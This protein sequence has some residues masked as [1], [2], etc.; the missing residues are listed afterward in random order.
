MERIVPVDETPASGARW[1]Y[2]RP[3]IEGVV[4]LG[5]VHGRNVGLPRHFHDEHQVTFVVSGRR[6]FFV[7]GEVTVLT[8]GEGTLIPAGVPHYSL[9]EPAGVVCL[10]AYIPAGEYAVS[11]MIEA[12]GLQWRKAG[13]VRWIELAAVIRQHWLGPARGAPSTGNVSNTSRS[14]S[15]AAIQAGMSREGY[16]RMFARHSGMPPHAHGVMHRLNQARRLLRVG[17]GIA[18]VAAETGFADQSHFGRW[19]LRAFGVTPGRYR[20]G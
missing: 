17:D 14:V 12:I 13:V 11:P 18:A 20:A 9:T 16:S 5:T 6:R 10:N 19:F 3:A 1:K 15:Q 8:A 7:R 2:W 4:E